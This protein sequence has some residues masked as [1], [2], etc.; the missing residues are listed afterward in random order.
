M[1][2]IC[3]RARNIILLSRCWWISDHQVLFLLHKSCSLLFVIQDHQTWDSGCIDSS[4]RLGWDLTI[5][6][7]MCCAFY[8]I[9]SFL[10]ASAL[11]T[12]S[13][14]AEVESSCSAFHFK[15]QIQVAHPK[16]F[17]RRSTICLS[18]IQTGL[19]S[20]PLALCFRRSHCNGE[21]ATHDPIDHCAVKLF[22]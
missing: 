13:Y 15:F 1:P 4:S 14:S 16:L 17:M 21:F 11:C 12:Y 18:V 10:V 7:T 20:V 8:V 5:R 22:T 2:I 9:V 6:K 19:G 3:V